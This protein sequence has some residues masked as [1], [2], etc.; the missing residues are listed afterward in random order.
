LVGLLPHLLGVV[1]VGRK[2]GRAKASFAKIGLRVTTSRHPSPRV[3]ASMPEEWRAIAA[4]W[5][6][7][8]LAVGCTWD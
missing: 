4:T 8:A 3:R 5:H 7:A 2:A 1:L 6:E